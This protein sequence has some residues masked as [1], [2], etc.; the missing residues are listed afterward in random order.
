MNRQTCAC[1]TF[2]PREARTCLVHGA[3]GDDRRYRAETQASMVRRLINWLRAVHT[4]ADDWSVITPTGQTGRGRGRPAPTTRAGR[5]RQLTW[6]VI[7][8]TDDLLQV[9]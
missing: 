5:A 6:A 1:D 2:Q 7:N 4:D 3:S 9:W 8:E